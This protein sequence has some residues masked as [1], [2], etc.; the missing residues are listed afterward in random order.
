MIQLTAH[1]RILVAVESVDFRKRIDGLSALCRSVLAE[2]P[3]SGTI[4]VFR[5][6]GA[7]SLRV[8]TYDGQGFWLAEKRLSAGKFR[9]WPVSGKGEPASALLAHQLQV[10]L[11]GGDPQAARGAPE[12]RRVRAEG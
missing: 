7:K 9:F 5:S 8:L 3:F 11:S 10:L 6:R 1:M 12:W 4:F 2:D